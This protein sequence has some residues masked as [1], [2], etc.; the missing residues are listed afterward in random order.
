MITCCDSIA[1]IGPG[2]YKELHWE[3]GYIGQILYLEAEA[4]GVRG[5]GMGCFFD[6][7]VREV[8]GLDG[9][10]GYQNLYNF[11]VGGPIEDTRLQTIDPYWDKL[12]R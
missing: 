9:R 6:D 10:S 2:A 7:P 11:T 3:C 1:S 12:N 4:K 8:F 5:T